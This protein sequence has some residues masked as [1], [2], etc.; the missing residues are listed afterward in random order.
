[1]YP[2]IAARRMAPIAAIARRTVVDRLG[3]IGPRGAG[4]GG[5]SMD[6]A[7]D[8]LAALRAELHVAGDLV[9]IRAP[10]G[11]S[12]AAFAAEL[13]APRGGLRALDARLGPRRD[14]RCGGADA[15]QLG[16]RG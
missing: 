5:A 9:A 12:R 11:L 2:K 13:Q 6:S 16:S 15:P 8:R 14:R 10:A 7:L 1:M 4:A 3:N